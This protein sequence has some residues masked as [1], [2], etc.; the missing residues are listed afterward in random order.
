MNLEKQR[1][2]IAEACGWK[3]VRRSKRWEFSDVS[4]YTDWCGNHPSGVDMLLPDYSDDLDAIHEAMEFIVHGPDI[5]EFRSNE[6]MLNDEIEYVASK[7]QV[8]IWRLNA[9]DYCKALLK[10][11]GKWEE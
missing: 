8:P 11:L 6:F 10:C 2:T 9:S 5:H 1:I 3:N 4:P 7:L